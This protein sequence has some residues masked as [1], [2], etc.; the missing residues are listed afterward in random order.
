M[1]IL[2]VDDYERFRA[3]LREI[4]AAPGVSF[5]EAGNGSEAIRVHRECNPDWILMDLDMPG[6]DG[7]AA[8]KAIRADDPCARI[9][10]VSQHRFRG[11][12]RRD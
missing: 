8:T 3:L 5:L 7:L 10:V 6:M 2:L 11:L 12:P 4:L 1:T 9:V